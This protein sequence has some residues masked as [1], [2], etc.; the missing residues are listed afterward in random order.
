ML[1]TLLGARPVQGEHSARRICGVID[2]W[3]SVGEKQ[4]FEIVF[5][6]KSILFLLAKVDIGLYK[7]PQSEGM[8]AMWDASIRR[9]MSFHGIP[10]ELLI[11]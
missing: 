4:I 11:H 10:L 8:P 2:C 1:L 7:H 6:R 9:V 5:F 3:E